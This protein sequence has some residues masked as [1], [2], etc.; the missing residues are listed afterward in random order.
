[1]CLCGEKSL[2][3]LRVC[4]YRPIVVKN[5]YYLVAV[6]QRSKKATIDYVKIGKESW[7]N[8]MKIMQISIGV[9]NVLKSRLNVFDIYKNQD[10]S[11]ILF[12]LLVVQIQCLKYRQFVL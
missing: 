4:R 9:I 8:I 5:I 3:C 12:F 11:I 1:M 6:Y 7:L 10:D 2:V